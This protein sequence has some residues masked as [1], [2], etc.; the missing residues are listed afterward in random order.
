MLQQGLVVNT[1][2]LN[3]NLR[4]IYNLSSTV[5][6]RVKNQVA[7]DDVFLMMTPL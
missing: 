4:S 1:G 3:G 2:A 5:F 7:A 6:H